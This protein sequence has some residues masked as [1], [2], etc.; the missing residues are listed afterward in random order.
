[1]PKVTALREE[2]DLPS[3]VRGPVEDSALRRL[4]AI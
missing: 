3:L 2:R 1:M 4:A